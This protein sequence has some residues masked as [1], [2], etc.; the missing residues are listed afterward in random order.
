[1]RAIDQLPTA[2]QG[3]DIEPVFPRHQPQV[4]FAGEAGI[5]QDHHSLTLG[6]RL[7]STEHLPKQDVAMPFPLRSQD[8]AAHGDAKPAPVCDEQ[9]QLQA[10]DIGR[11][12]IHPRLVSQRCPTPALLFDRQ[13][14]DQIDRPVRGRREGEQGSLCQVIDQRGSVPVSGLNQ[15]QDGPIAD[16]ARHHSRQV[17]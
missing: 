14:T 10:E 15:P 7:K 2:R 17:F 6:R 13:I 16:A 5:G 1:M 12:M 11:E 9:N 4:G 3:K 8:V